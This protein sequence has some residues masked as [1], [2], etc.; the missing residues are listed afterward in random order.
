MNYFVETNLY[1]PEMCSSNPDTLY[2]FGDNFLNIGLSGQAV[3]RYLPNSFGIPTKLFPLTDS[4][5]YLTD[6]DCHKYNYVM[7]GYYN[8]IFDRLTFVAES[9]GFSSVAFPAGGLGTGLSRMPELAPKLLSYIDNLVSKLIN[10]DYT[11]YRN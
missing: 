7:Q 8:E 4:F 10:E 1:S 11:K 9:E 3:I 2:V 5:A 6:H